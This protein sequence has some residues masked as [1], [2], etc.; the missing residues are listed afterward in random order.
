MAH[1][2]RFMEKVWL[3]SKL[4][5]LKICGLQSPNATDICWAF[6]LAA[7]SSSRRLFVCLSVGLSVGWNT[8]VKKLSLEYQMVTL[9]YL[10]FNLYDTSDSSDSSDQSVQQLF[11]PINFFH[12]KNNFFSQL[13][14]FLQETSFHKKKLLSQKKTQKLKFN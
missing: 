1:S 4:H 7:Q 14:F 10:P 5:W 12:Q 2:V 9:T 8:F 6:F 13:Y 11:S 3:K